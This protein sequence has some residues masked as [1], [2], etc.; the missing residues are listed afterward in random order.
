MST[1]LSH[2]VLILSPSPLSEL[3]DPKTHLILNSFVARGEGNCS[4]ESA[5]TQVRTLPLCAV[6]EE[7]RADDG[8][9]SGAVQADAGGGCATTRREHPSFPADNP[10][11]FLLFSVCGFLLS[12][13]PSPLLSPLSPLHPSSLS[14][15]VKDELA[16]LTALAGVSLR[17][18]V[19]DVLLEL[20]RLNVV[21]T[22][23]AQVLKSLCTKSQS[24]ASMGAVGETLPPS[25]SASP[26]FTLNPQW[27][28]DCCV[29]CHRV[30][31]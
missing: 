5:Q 2:H 12:L 18:E 17:P 27:S 13:T 9:S 19:F 31:Q 26:P 24:R 10:L 21:P 25:S 30:P 4:R 7:D 29:S 28:P 14:L 1:F 20:T 6:G 15:A 16:H 23:I 22:A 11:V 8:D 3:F